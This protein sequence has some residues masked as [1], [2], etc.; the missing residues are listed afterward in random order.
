MEWLLYVLGFALSGMLNPTLKQP[1]IVLR[2][3]S[4]PLSLHKLFS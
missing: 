4:M 1:M 2:R 3:L